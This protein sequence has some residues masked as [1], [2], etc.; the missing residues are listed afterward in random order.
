MAI[1]M[2]CAT[3]FST[4]FSNKIPVGALLLVSDIPMVPEGVKTDESD[5]QVTDTFADTHLKIGIDSLRQLINN[6]QT[7]RHLKF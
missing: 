6:S 7:V 4:G 3:I 5:K 2:E 1:D